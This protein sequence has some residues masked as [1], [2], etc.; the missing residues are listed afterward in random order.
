MYLW[1]NFRINKTLVIY[2]TCLS[3]TPRNCLKCI[4][5]RLKAREV[6]L[7]LQPF[8]CVPSTSFLECAALIFT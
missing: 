8:K 2:V 4:Q 1:L 3:T 7:T 6:V 5:I